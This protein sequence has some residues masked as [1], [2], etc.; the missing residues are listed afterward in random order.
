M[1]QAKLIV[2]IAFVGMAL[3]QW[4]IPARMILSKTEVLESGVAYKFRTAPLD[5]TDPFRGKYITLSYEDSTI[6]V[7]DPENWIRNETVYALITADSLG[8]ARI[9]AVSKKAFAEEGNFI[10]TKVSATGP[11]S[12]SL[13]YPFDRFYMEEHKAPRAEKAYRQAL[14]D[15][16]QI[17]YALVYIK[18]GDAVLSDV[19]ING[20]SVKDLPQ[21]Q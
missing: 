14:Q 2:L 7:E 12:V 13:E 20:V 19:V 6:D 21:T 18:N 10:K 15:S 11:G 8:F 3:L 5:P 4:Y 9:K 1:N 17:T 16:S